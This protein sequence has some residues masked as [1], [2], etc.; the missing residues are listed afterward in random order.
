MV[1]I[2]DKFTNS[3]NKDVNPD[4]VWSHLETMYNLEALDESESLPF[5][6]DEREFTLPESDFGYLQIKKEEKLETEKKNVQKGRETPKL[7]KDLKKEEKTPLNISNVKDSQRRDSKDSGKDVKMSSVKKEAK[8]ELE[9]STPKGNRG[10]TP[11]EDKGNKNKI[12]ETPR[13]AKRPLRNS[14][15]ADD[16]GSSGKASPVTVTPSN[17]KRRRVQ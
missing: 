4:K 11:K 3:V 9:K 7:V 15:K 14:L 6:N 16:S 10:R 1:I 17:A 8:K 12:D 5:P 2:L 13:A